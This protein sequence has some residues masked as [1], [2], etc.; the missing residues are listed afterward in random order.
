MERQKPANVAD[1]LLLFPEDTQK[2]LR[3]IRQAIK[4]GAPK[5]E[6][7][8]SYAI[9]AF[10]LNGKPFIYMAAFKNHVS[11]YPAPRGEAAFKKELAAYK[12]GK[13]TVQFPLDEPI[14]LDLITRIT[15][16]RVQKNTEA[17]SI[18]KTAARPSK[19]NSG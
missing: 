12:G 8:I 6:E 18:K 19:Q 11:V 2:V 13:G 5:A 3:K 7:T 4:K 10:K 15:E 17:A 16:F 14:P 1:Y 9:P